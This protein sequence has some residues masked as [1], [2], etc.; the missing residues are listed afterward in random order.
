VPFIDLGSLVF[1]VLNGLNTP[2]KYIYRRAKLLLQIPFNRHINQSPATLTRHADRGGQVSR[3]EDASAGTRK[4]NLA[5][6]RFGYIKI[7]IDI[8]NI[9]VDIVLPAGASSRLQQ[10][11]HIESHR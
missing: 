8:D 1:A 11:S 6:Q 4:P 3:C 2:G 9:L 5:Y 10:L 7:P